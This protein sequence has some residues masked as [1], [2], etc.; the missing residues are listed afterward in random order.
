MRWRLTGT[1][2]GDQAICVP[3]Q[4]FEAL[5]GFPDIPVMEDLEFAARLR[6]F[7]SIRRIPLPAVSS[8]RVW[9]QY[10]LMRPTLVNATGIA[11]YRL[12]VSPQRIAGWRQRIAAR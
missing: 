10:G 12:G 6:R 7:G 4:V 9:E 3:R 5:G 2:Y 11:A 8:A 1:P